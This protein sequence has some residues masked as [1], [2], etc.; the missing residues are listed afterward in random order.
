MAPISFIGIVTRCP[1]VLKLKRVENCASWSAVL[2]Y[3]D[4]IKVLQ[5]PSD[6]GSA[7]S[8]GLYFIH[9]KNYIPILFIKIPRIIGFTHLHRVRENC[10]FFIAQNALAGEGKGISEQMISLEIKSSKVPD[11][12]L[13]DLPGIARVATGDQPIDIEKQVR[14][15]REN[16][17]IF[18][19]F[20]FN[21]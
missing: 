13:I 9:F 19:Q 10:A 16:R 21:L 12:T 14:Q 8:S 17:I 11:L 5:S 20:Y 2:T 18:F 6:V 3:K 7:V 1:L 15:N 4:Q